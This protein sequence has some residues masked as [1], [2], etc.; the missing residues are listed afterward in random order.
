VAEAEIV[1]AFDA[2]IDRPPCPVDM[3]SDRQQRFATAAMAAL[4]NVV[5]VAV[6]REAAVLV[7]FGELLN[8]GPHQPRPGS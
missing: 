5:T 6:D 7:L 3:P 2:R 4:E 8:P 1:F